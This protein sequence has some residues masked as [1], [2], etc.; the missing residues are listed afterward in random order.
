MI[1]GFLSVPQQGGGLKKYEEKNRIYKNHPKSFYVYAKFK[2]ADNDSRNSKEFKTISWFYNDHKGEKR[3]DVTDNGIDFIDCFIIHIP[4]YH[5]L[6]TRY[7]GFY[8][9]ASKKTL[10]KVHALL[11]ILKN[12][13]Y[14]RETRT[15][16]LKNK[17]DKFRY[18]THLIDSFNLRSNSM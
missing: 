4:D 3:H 13:D 1:C 7:D 15:K 8:A 17:L 11:K 6:T 2:S 18:Y 5:F 9:N 16:A 14:S 12:K 10:N